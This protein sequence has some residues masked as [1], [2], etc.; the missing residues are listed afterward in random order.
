[1][2]FQCGTREE[3]GRLSPILRRL[4]ETQLYNL[5]RQLSSTSNRQL[6]ERAQWFIV[7]QHAGSPV[8][9]LQYPDSRVRQG[10]VSLHHPPGLFPFYGYA[11]RTH[12]RALS[13]STSDGRGA[14]RFVLSSVSGLPRRYHR[15]REDL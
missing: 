7:V 12:L 11:V 4:P 3:K 10:Q 2:G 5:Q 9:I 15:L 6:L 14:V 8:G 13:L 1:M